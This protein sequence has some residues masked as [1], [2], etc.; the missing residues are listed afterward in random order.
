MT[1]YIEQLNISFVKPLK[2]PFILCRIH[3]PKQ[4]ISTLCIW[5]ILETLILRRSKPRRVH[6]T[7]L[8]HLR[9]IT[10]VESGRL[11]VKGNQFTRPTHCCNAVALQS[12]CCGARSAWR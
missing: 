12:F 2:Y 9:V 10:L 11:R 1:E 7:A 6:A 5:F 4:Q 8:P 3:L